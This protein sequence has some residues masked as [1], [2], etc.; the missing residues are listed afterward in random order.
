VTGDEASRAQS[1]FGNSGEGGEAL[2]KNQAGGAAGRPPRRQATKILGYILALLPVSTCPM[3]YF[4]PNNQEIKFGI[5]T[6]FALYSKSIAPLPEA[7]RPA[8]IL[9]QPDSQP[10]SPYINEYI[11]A[12]QVQQVSGLRLTSFMPMRSRGGFDGSHTGGRGQ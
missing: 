4:S 11:T 2:E 12:Q 1:T 9:R 3:V 6:T 8:R 10:A 7:F 5:A